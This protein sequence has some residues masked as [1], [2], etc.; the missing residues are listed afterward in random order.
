MMKS[1]ALWLNEVLEK[2]SDDEISPLVN[3]GSSTEHFRTVE[4]PHIDEYVFKPLRSRDVKIIHSDLKEGE[5]VD[6]SADIFD[7]E[8]LKKLKALKPKALICTHMLE[9]VEDRE[10]L[11]QRLMSIL[12]KDGVFFI[13]V[14]FSYH[15][16]AD[17]I[18]TMY[19]PAPE[20]LAELFGGQKILRKDVLIDG[21][22]WGKIRQRPVTLFFRHL[23]RLPFPFVNF[24]KWKRSTKKLYW[25]FHHY[26][27][28]AI[29]GQKV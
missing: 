28:S 8:A 9:H 4:Q 1:D 24:A 2:F 27:V 23:M 25:L 7:D 22:Y 12:P 11:A 16:H 21:T 14:P 15:H 10:L 26:K 3:I 18:D 20:E 19:R 6:I 5:G 17:P 13:T 29:V